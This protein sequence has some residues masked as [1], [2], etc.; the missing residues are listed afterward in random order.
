MVREWHLAQSEEGISITACLSLSCLVNA[1]L[2]EIQTCNWLIKVSFKM[3]SHEG[4]G[5]KA[6]ELMKLDFRNL[7]CTF[8]RS[9][10]I[11]KCPPQQCFLTGLVRDSHLEMGVN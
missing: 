6:H 8:L 10:L 4:I 9:H 3:W 5:L 11:T 2:T 7:S 1:L